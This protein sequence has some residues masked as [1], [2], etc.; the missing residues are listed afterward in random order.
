MA[1]KDKAYKAFLNKARALMLI[2]EENEVSSIHLSYT[3]HQKDF[4][5]QNAD[6][7][8]ALYSLSIVKSRFQEKCL[9][10][11]DNNHLWTQFTR[12]MKVYEITTG[13][14]TEFLRK[15]TWIYII[16]SLNWGLLCY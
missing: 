3:L 4:S 8:S 2:A 9:A 7:K 1:A 13:L 15:S 6:C 16:P 12:W 14:Y 10:E 5:A 11:P